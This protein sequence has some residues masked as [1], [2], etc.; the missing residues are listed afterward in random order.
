MIKFI[1]YIIC[2]TNILPTGFPEILKPELPLGNSI[3][4]QISTLNGAIKVLI[5]Y[6]CDLIPN[7]CVQ[8]LS[9]D[10]AEDISREERQFLFALERTGI[11]VILKRDSP[12][13]KSFY[14]RRR[15]HQ[16]HI[17]NADYVL[18][19]YDEMTSEIRNAIKYAEANAAAYKVISCE[20][21]NEQG[22][23]YAN[24]TETIH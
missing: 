10:M 24:A 18:I 21:S 20:N 23:S 12:V 17:K 6:L 16:H 4:F 22:E 9:E 8:Y 7:A 5:Q 14:A 1:F 15:R 11:E 2:Q 3:V 13:G 19:V